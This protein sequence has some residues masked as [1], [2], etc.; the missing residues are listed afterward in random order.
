MHAEV[1]LAR[2]S[3]RLALRSAQAALAGGEEGILRQRRTI[4]AVARAGIDPAFDEAFLAAC[5]RNLAEL[6]MWRRRLLEQPDA[7]L[8]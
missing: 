5:D 2:P 1:P 8:P 7:E 3:D 6:N 4:A